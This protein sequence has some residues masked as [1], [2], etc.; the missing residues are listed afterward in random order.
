MKI[1]ASEINFKNE[2]QSFTTRNKYNSENL[3]FDIY[4]DYGQMHPLKDCELEKRMI[5]LLR[6][7]ME[8]FESPPEQYQRIGI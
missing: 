5:A 2:S 1:P 6:H 4:S 7:T 8:K 3:L